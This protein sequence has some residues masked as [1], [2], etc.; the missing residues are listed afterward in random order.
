MAP[1][2][3]VLRVVAGCLLVLLEIAVMQSAASLGQ[4][5]QYGP[6][7]ALKRRLSSTNGNFWTLAFKQ[8]LSIKSGFKPPPTRKRSRCRIAAAQDA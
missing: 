7:Q 8:K 3:C 4:K 2:F 1:A 5:M 6:P